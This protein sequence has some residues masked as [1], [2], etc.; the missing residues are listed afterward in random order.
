VTTRKH[1]YYYPNTDKAGSIIAL[2]GNSTMQ[3]NGLICRQRDP[4]SLPKPINHYLTCTVPASN[5]IDAREQPLQ[6]F[7]VQSLKSP[8]LSTPYAVTCPFNLSESGPAASSDPSPVLMSSHGPSAIVWLTTRSAFVVCT[9]NSNHMWIASSTVLHAD[10]DNKAPSKLQ[11][12]GFQKVYETLSASL[13]LRT[14][15]NPWS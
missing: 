3:T 9:A 11:P 12:I 5:S 6:K 14:R 10:S 2:I 7:I 15:R 8:V 13:L 4:S 1:S